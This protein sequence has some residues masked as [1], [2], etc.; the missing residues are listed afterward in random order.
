MKNKVLL[1]LFP[2]I[3]LINSFV[4]GDNLQKAE[5]ALTHATTYHWL[6]RYKNN[7][8]ND[9]LKSKE[10]F[11]QA[12]TYLD[13]SDTTHYTKLLRDK[14][15]LGLTDTDIRYENCFGYS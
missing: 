1:Y 7:D 2:L 14:A 3:L 15:Q 5:D 10:Y 4:F 12:L 13:I 8:A 11:S 9:L 6:A